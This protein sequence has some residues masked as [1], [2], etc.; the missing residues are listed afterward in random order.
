MKMK[1]FLALM[2]TISLIIGFAGC[3]GGDSGDGDNG[4][5]GDDGKVYEWKMGTIYNDPVSRPDFNAFGESMQTF[6][7]LVNERSEGRIVITPFYNSVLG[8]SGE[9]YDQMRR[10]ELEVFYG[11][12]MSNID[13]RFGVFNLP[14]IMSDYDQVLELVAN[15]D[16]ELYK[17]GQELVADNGGH[18]VS[19]GASLFRGFFNTKKRVATVDDM[20]G[21][22]VRTY[23]DP[24]V[25]QFWAG[26]SNAAPMPYSEVYTGLQT[27]AVDGLEFAATSVVSSKFYEV[28][29]F[30]SDINWQWTWGANIIISQEKWDELPD[31]LKQIVSDAAWEAMEVQYELESANTSKAIDELKNN[32]V[33]VYNL[34]DEERA[35]WIDYARSLDETFAEEIGEETVQRVLDA[36]ASLE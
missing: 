33:E 4:D 22:K 19:S 6:I 31:D 10:G 32:G 21:L 36:I 35:T 9:L 24:I 17:L 23:E 16:G 20:E 12:P 30:Y 11:Q 29:K 25:H 18:L 8:A 28:G 27:N 14:Y 1:K 26:I 2:V 13:P 7:D 34:T 3:S 15:P 5:G